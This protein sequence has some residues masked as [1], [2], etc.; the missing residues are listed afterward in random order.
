MKISVRVK[1]NARTDSFKLNEDGSARVTV[2]A[3][4]EDGKANEAVVAV[5]AEVLG[6][7]KTSIRVVTARSRTKIVEVPD[8]SWPPGVA[9]RGTAR[10][11]H[12][13]IISLSSLVI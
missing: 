12:P 9:A 8:G 7:P 3:Q 1:P 13:I 4:P 2:R 6:V 10:G 11:T 5:L